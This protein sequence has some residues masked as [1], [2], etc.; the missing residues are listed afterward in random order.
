MDNSPI[1]DENDVNP[2]TNPYFY[3][4][5]PL[6]GF[7]EIL[8]ENPFA[9]S[10]L[11][12]GET[13]PNLSSVKRTTKNKRKSS[14]TF[15]STSPLIEQSN[16]NYIIRK[17]S[18]KGRKLIKIDMFDFTSENSDKNSMHKIS[19]Q[20]VVKGNYDEIEDTAKSLINKI[21]KKINE[22]IDSD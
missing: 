17:E 15:R 13:I 14:T 7:P 16:L 20:Y 8:Q 9:S 19:V 22:D 1:F 10:H 18:E 11:K 5:D 2:I 12:A 21:V 6:A 4:Q 3:A